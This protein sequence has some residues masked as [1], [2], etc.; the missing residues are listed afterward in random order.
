MIESSFEQLRPQGKIKKEQSK[1]ESKKSSRLYDI[2]EAEGG[3]FDIV[4]PGLL[5][6]KEGLIV[7]TS[8]IHC[9]NREEAEEK[10][11]SSKENIRIQFEQS[12]LEKREPTSEEDLLRAIEAE[13]NVEK[14]NYFEIREKIEALD[15]EKAER[16]WLEVG[17]ELKKIGV[18][19]NLKQE[20][21]DIFEQEE[22]WTCPYP[23]DH[24]SQEDIQKEF[25]WDYCNIGGFYKD[26]RIGVEESG[27]IPN[28]VKD[29]L[30]FLAAGYG[31]GR[32]ADTFI[33]ETYH[34][35]QDIDP[36]EAKQYRSRIDELKDKIKIAEMEAEIKNRPAYN[37]VPLRDQLGRLEKEMKEHTSKF[38]Q[39]GSEEDIVNHHILAEAHSHMFAD[40][41]KYIDKI[42]SYTKEEINNAYLN[43]P[44]KRIHGM[45]SKEEVQGVFKYD[46]MK[47]KEN[48]AHMA[49]RQ[50]EALRALGMNNLEI[51]RII[52]EDKWDTEKEKFKKLRTT[53]IELMDE[54]EINSEG[55]NEMTERFRL[56]TVYEAL[57]AQNIT[58]DI[59]K[60][61]I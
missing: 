55:L 23:V 50:I 61:Y 16:A 47:G 18:F 6:K 49:F 54:K 29:N 26:G 34:G 33:H 53:L 46:Y 30:A 12:S 41:L 31:L 48:R 15:Q 39:G 28:A 8:K 40:P 60:K 14:I 22:K 42:K 20:G 21:I 25:G 24:L 4:M 1:T 52:S 59:L 38:K 9:E 13:D 10:V 19:E 58:K 37:A 2:S 51:G 45:I 17:E 36:E 56:K 27:D 57:K 35:F 11:R 44:V 32:K 7:G 5:D 3:G 43:I